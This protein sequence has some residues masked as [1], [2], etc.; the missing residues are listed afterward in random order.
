MNIW[1]A[2]LNHFFGIDYVS[3]SVKGEYS[4]SPSIDKVCRVQVLPTGIE[5]IRYQKRNYT[6]INR[7]ELIN[8]AKQ[9]VSFQPLT[10]VN[11]DV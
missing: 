3:I 9:P 6:F 11:E 2:F 8:S 5:Y 7:K 1:Y 10:W 4:Y